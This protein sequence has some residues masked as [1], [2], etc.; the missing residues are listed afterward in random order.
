MTSTY[1]PPTP[2][3]PRTHTPP[4]PPAAA[5]PVLRRRHAA[6]G[7]R[8]AALALSVSTSLGL[9][10]YLQHLDSAASAGETTTLAVTPT[11]AVT[12]STAPTTAAT[13]STTET[14]P[15][16]TTPTTT[17]APT[18]TTSGLADG[19]YAGATFTN[20]WGDVQVQVTVSGGTI[21]SVDALQL[22]DDDRK[23]V[24][25]NK[26]AYPQLV[27]MSLTAQSADVD[28]VS[29][30]TYTSEGYRDSLQTAIDAARA[31]AAS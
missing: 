21:A 4:P 23:S 24:S 31:A 16:I 2:S 30:A 6:K 7:S 9:A 11:A 20:R 10:G 12:A 29:G 8:A 13:E 1:P 18:V 19:T 5:A 17:P 28:T 25:I 14:A 15:T 3:R 26:R 27:Q 22:P